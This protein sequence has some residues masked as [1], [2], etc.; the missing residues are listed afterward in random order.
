MTMQT[1]NNGFIK[2]HCFENPFINTSSIHEIFPLLVDVLRTRF[3]GAIVTIMV[4]DEHTQTLSPGY[5]GA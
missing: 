1:M 4:Y 3:S 2:T 5:H